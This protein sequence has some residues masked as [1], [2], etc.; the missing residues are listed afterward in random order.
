MNSPPLENTEEIR[1]NLQDFHQHLNILIANTFSDGDIAP[2]I[3]LFSRD[4]TLFGWSGNAMGHDEIVT[5]YAAEVRR[6]KDQVL[7]LKKVSIDT[8]QI[9]TY[10]SDDLKSAWMFGVQRLSYHGAAESESITARFTYT[11]FRN[12][13]YSNNWLINHLHSSKG[14]GFNSLPDA[15][16]VTFT[17]WYLTYNIGPFDSMII[18]YR[19]VWSHSCLMSRY[20]MKLLMINL[21]HFWIAAV[22]FKILALM[23]KKREV[24]AEATRKKRRKYTSVI[25]VQCVVKLLF[26]NM[27]CPN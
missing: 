25:D 7:G 24:S 21:I 13:A 19:S 3:R 20:Y 16:D 22:A 10:L 4:A 1:S 2:L 26:L 17:V 12:G 27:I 9:K 11:L 15:T 6:V 5:H 14:R 8:L 23:A 18:I